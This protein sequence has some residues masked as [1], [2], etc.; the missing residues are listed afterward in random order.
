MSVKHSL[1]ALL[2]QGPR[3]GYH[4]RAE[5]EERTGST[6][7]LNIGQVYTTLD[8]LERDGLVEDQGDDGAGHRI[9]A[10]TEAGRAETEDWFAQ[11]SRPSN[12][13]RN[14]LAIKL[15]IAVT[16]QGVDVE[17]VIQAQRSATL[18]ALQD[19]TRAKRSTGGESRPADLAGLLVL[20]SLIFTAEAEIRWLDHCEAAVL[21][22]ARSGQL[23]AAPA[24][25]SAPAPAPTPSRTAVPTTAG[26]SRRHTSSQQKDR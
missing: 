13:P 25:V 24:A 19:V 1:L 8:R 3:Y 14:E 11:P 22:A 23:P 26:T 20:E 12:P 9:Y 16:T 5:F 17:R 2:T 18:R 7:P 6:W 15:A 4:L 21:R 10:I